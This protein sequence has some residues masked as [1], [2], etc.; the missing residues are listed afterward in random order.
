MMC[1]VYGVVF[2]L[3]DLNIG[4]VVWFELIVIGF[5]MVGFVR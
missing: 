3:D 4:F 5:V 1:V 2:L